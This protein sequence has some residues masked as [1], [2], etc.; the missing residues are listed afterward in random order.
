M[1]NVTLLTFRHVMSKR[2]IIKQPFE[3][4]TSLLGSERFGI[5]KF[6]KWLPHISVEWAC[7]SICYSESKAWLVTNR[8]HCL[9][10][11]I[12]ENE[13]ILKAGKRFYAWLRIV[14]ETMWGAEQTSLCCSGL[15]TLPGY[16]IL[17]SQKASNCLRIFFHENF[18][19]IFKKLLKYN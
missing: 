10:V 6:L 5:N 8:L 17:Q 12:V 11:K 9:C 4:Q 15:R 18:I 16:I 1:A 7:K 13:G 3:K 14:T 2:M 19:L